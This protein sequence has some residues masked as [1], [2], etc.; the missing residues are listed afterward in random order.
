MANQADA[1]WKCCVGALIALGFPV[2]CEGQEDPPLALVGGRVIVRAGE[3]PLENATVIL[4]NGR[5]ESVGPGADIPFDARAVDVAGLTLTPAFLDAFSQGSLS[6]AERPVLQGRPYDTHEDVLVAMPEG[7]RRGLFPERDAASALAPDAA[8]DALRRAAG[9][10]AVFV[11][12][13]GELLSGSGA[14]LALS[15]RPPRE[16]LLQA[17]TAQ[18]CSL[19]WRTGP[20]NYQGYDYP[21]TLM[22]VMAHLRQILLDAQREELIADRHAHDDPPRRGVEDPALNS[23]RSVLQ[24]KRPLVVIAHE[25]EDIRLALGLA[26]EFPGVSIV[27][28]GGTEAWKLAPELVARHVPVIH[29]LRFGKEPVVAADAATHEEEEAQPEDASHREEGAAA[30]AGDARRPWNPALPERLLRDRHDRWLANVRGVAALKAAGIDLSFGSFGRTPDELLASLR[31][32]IEK[33]GLSADDALDALTRGPRAIFGARA[34]SGELAAGAVAQVAAFEGDPLASDARVRVIVADGV[35]FDLREL[36]APKH[37]EK[38]RK[39]KQSNAGAG[40]TDTDS[41]AGDNTH[42]SAPEATASIAVETATWPVELDSDRVPQLRTGGNVLVHGAT[43]LTVSHGSLSDHDLLVRDGKIAA[44]GQGLEAPEGVAVID[45]S[46]Q[47]LIPGIIDCHSHVAIRGGINEWTRVITPECTIEDEVDPEDVNLYRALAGGV[48]TARLLHGSSNA[49]G[50]RHEIIKLRWGRSAPELV[51]DGA[52]RGVKFALGE[53]PKQS[54]GGS[55]ERFPRT[56]MGVEAVLRRA[57][58]AGREYADT[59]SAYRAGIAAGMALDVPRRDLRLE[60]LAGIVDGSIGVHSHC[61][62]ADEMLMLLRV[63]EDFGIQVK[64]LQHVLEGYKVAAEIAAHGAGGSTFVDWWAYKFEVWDATPYNAALMNEAGVLMSVNSD[65]DEHLRRL[66]LEAAKTC[67]YGGVPEEQALAMVTLNPARQLGIESRVGSIDVGKDADFALFNLHP[68]DVR[69]QCQMTFV[70]GELY[71]QRRADRYDDFARTVVDRIAAGRAAAEAAPPAAPPTAL[72]LRVRHVDPASLSALGLVR[73]ATRAPSTPV[74]PA[75]PAIALVGGTVHTM[76]RDGDA[77]TVYA[78]GVVLMEHGT[79]RGVY[80]GHDAPP[81]GFI[82]VDVSGQHVWPGF[83]DA[84]CQIGLTEIDSVQGTADQREIGTDQPDLRASAAYHADSEH[85]AVARVNGTTTA[86]VTPSAAR[87]AGL[88]S[89]M[90]LEGWTAN[91]ALVMDGVALHVSAPRTLREIVKPEDL[92]PAS[93]HGG[94]GGLGGHVD[95]CEGGPTSGAD[96]DDDADMESDE[97]RPLGDR[98]ADN[99][100]ELRALF[101]DAREYA[102]VAGEAERRGVPP[103]GHDARLEALAPFAL[104]QSPVV[105]DAGWADQ[106]MD[107]LDFAEENGLRPIIAGG[108]QAWMVAD[109]LALADV[110]VI[111][112]PVLSLPFERHELYDAPLHN[113]AA[114]HAA[115]VRICFRS[116]ASSSAR[117]LPYHAGMAVAFGL[118]EDEALYALTAGAAQILGLS[119]RV[120]TLAPGKRGDVIVTDG[121]PLQIRSALTHLYIGGRDVGLATRHTRL[122]E[123]YRGRLLDP[124]QPNR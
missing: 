34:P 10:G 77:L 103:P 120:G 14:L 36:P 72:E 94:H 117:D 1:V 2:L 64:T 44:I 23:L 13:T 11:S 52:P 74:R 25:A 108:Q 112:G 68:F 4:R 71:F 114:L 107:V 3:A 84:G 12:P 49:I 104:G 98:L 8:D 102:R 51:F 75:G 65:S 93:D 38:G 58:Q 67:K 7:Y 66:Y 118:P 16:A 54:N 30:A 123:R 35:L 47:F 95:L 32:V 81:E 46:G 39:E 53:N 99:W 69:T 5:V 83:L 26:T 122:Y 31:T 86:L 100:A 63:A 22:G 121:N 82:V 88:S 105:F 87:I 21:A 48:T 97:D 6:F 28:A 80:A 70:D 42:E 15:S 20:E 40:I 73:D 115:G 37:S 79:I 109:R 29:D 61:Y 78:P 43:I 59:W 24:G 62:Q 50:G 116:N 91:D 57:L 55:G 33:G 106:I 19:E 76:E 110:P 111:V 60:A 45:A 92:G 9:F 90:A 101:A 96:G 17:E 56:R 113:A 89:A 18:V 27:V 119:D 124:A 85:V 41:D